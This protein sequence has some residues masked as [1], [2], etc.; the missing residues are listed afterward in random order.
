MQHAMRMRP[1][2]LSSVD[3]PVASYISTLSHKRKHFREKKRLL[4]IKCVFSTYKFGL[5]HLL[6]IYFWPTLY[7]LY[8]IHFSLQEELSEILPEM[9][10]YRSSCEVPSFLSDFN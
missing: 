5:I 7:N 10:I 8:L 4:I 3:C 2:M 9:Y 1:V 6:Y